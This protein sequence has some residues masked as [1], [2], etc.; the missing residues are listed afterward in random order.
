M[1]HKKLKHPLTLITALLLVMIAGLA[2]ST[3]IMLRNMH[4]KSAHTAA[5][6]TVFNTGRSMVQKIASQPSVISTNSTTDWNEFSNL[7][8]NL[9]SIEGGL[10]YVSVTRDNIVV[11]HE[12][13]CRL[14]NNYKQPEPQPSPSNNDIRIQR[15]ILHVAGKSIPVV[16]FSTTVP[17]SGESQTNIRLALRKDTVAREEQPA[18]KAITSMFR[19]TLLTVI[20]SFTI[21]VILVVWMMRREIKRE[22]RRRKDEHLA[23]SGMLANGIVH[24]FRNPMSSMKLDVQMLHREANKS[25]TD[26]NRISTLANRVRNTVDRMD[27]VFQE[28]L[29][30]SRPDQDKR[31]T[32]NLI[33]C[34]EESLDMLTSRFE[35]ADISSK[36]NCSESN[37][38]VLAYEGSLRRALVNILTNAIQFSPAKS[39]V[40]VNLYSTA[41]SS[42]IEVS[43]Q[44]HG[45]AKSKRKTVFEMFETE[46]P[47]GTGLGLFIAK[48]AIERN[49]GIIEIIANDNNKGTLVRVRLPLNSKTQT[50]A[51]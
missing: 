15:E 47:E 42:I 26:T 5:A 7:I 38:S 46:R 35:N 16:V 51:Q 17:G 10:Q 9:H 31:T 48:A 13:T 30:V 25:Q 19:L 36:L 1:N 6:E 18:D 4:G 41:N 29:Y 11:F 22:S 14:E 33:S 2:G 39:T 44:G 8:R 23:F 32:I 24:D 34:I 27:K 28:F 49:N 45:I 50:L 43:D 40:T 21:C 37:I 12:Q 20:I 3:L